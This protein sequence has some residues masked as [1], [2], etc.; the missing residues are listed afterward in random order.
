MLFHLLFFGLLF[1]KRVT[2]RPDETH[3][4]GPIL[5]GL[6]GRSEKKDIELSCWI[7]TTLFMIMLFLMYLGDVYW[8]QEVDDDRVRNLVEYERVFIL[9]FS[10]LSLIDYLIF[11]VSMRRIIPVRFR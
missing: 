5:L 7:I 2:S 10:S 8:S 9:C 3:G 6:I 4:E 11:M 1:V